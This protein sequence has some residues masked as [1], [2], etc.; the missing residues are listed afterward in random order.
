M[1]KVGTDTH[2]LKSEFLIYF[3]LPNIRGW[4]S[5]LVSALNSHK[6]I[7]WL[8]WVELE[9]YGPLL[10]NYFRLRGVEE[11]LHK[12]LVSI[13]NFDK[14]QSV[15]SIG[16]NSPIELFNCIWS[17]QGW[18]KNLM[19]NFSPIKAI[20]EC[21][22]HLWVSASSNKHLCNWMSIEIDPIG[23]ILLFNQG[24]V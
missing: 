5:N 22:Q 8:I 7:D 4:Q 12:M 1:I 15:L 10:P 24:S 3:I 19:Q 16:P 14:I 13:A 9:R 23:L 6:K 18:P 21:W 2:I 17:S 20:T 11:G